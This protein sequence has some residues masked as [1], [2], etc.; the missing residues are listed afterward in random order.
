M[1][2][3][4]HII[5]SLFLCTLF[6]QCNGNVFVEE[7][8]PAVTEYTLN[9]DGD[10]ITIQFA[11]EDWDVSGGYTSVYYPDMWTIYDKNGNPTITGTQPHWNGLGKC[12]Y[13]DTLLNLEV[14]RDHPD[15]LCV[16]IHENAYKDSVSLTLAISNS[17]ATQP[18]EIRITP[19][20][21]YQLSRIEYQLSAFSH[22]ATEETHGHSSFLNQAYG[23]T[24]RFGI[25]IFQNQYN[26]IWFENLV[27]QMSQILA[28]DTQVEIPY[29][30]PNGTP[31]L[32]LSQQKVPYSTE[33]QNLPLNYPDLTEWIE[34]PPYCNQNIY[35]QFVYDKIGVYYNLYAVNPKSGKERL[36]NGTFYSRT[37]R[38]TDYKIIQ[39]TFKK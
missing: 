10:S 2:S 6:C 17:F 25:H 34:I 32:T 3:V 7:F 23:D 19:A 21:R 18:I 8:I 27:P 33:Y 30:N 28:P 36:I 37:P 15:Q 38:Q 22:E 14:A 16:K 35:T 12:Q 39:E 31:P 26:Q 24:I 20:T 1:K 5:L 29:Y 11:S 9:G 4:I 13:D